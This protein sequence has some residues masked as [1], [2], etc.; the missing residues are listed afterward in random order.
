MY[1]ELVKAYT[2]SVNFITSLFTLG[3]IFRYLVEE[4]GAYYTSMRCRQGSELRLKWRTDKE[5]YYWMCTPSCCGRTR[6]SITKGSFFYN[7]K[8]DLRLVFFVVRA[9]ILR[10]SV[11]AIMRETKMMHETVAQIVRDLYMIVKEDLTEDD[12]MLGKLISGLID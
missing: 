5:Q 12:L 2:I 1:V 6:I 4:L 7:R 11:G 10:H 8:A 3:L 9:F